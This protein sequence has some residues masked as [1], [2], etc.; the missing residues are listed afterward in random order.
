MLAQTLGMRFIEMTPGRFLMGSPPD[1]IGREADEQQHEVMLTRSFWIADAP[2]TVAQYRVKDP[3]HK[4]P[5]LFGIALDD[6]RYPC[7]WISIEEAKAYCDWLSAQDTEWTYELPTEAE[8]EYA[9]RAGTAGRFFWGDTEADASRFANTFDRSAMKAL[10]NL[11]KDGFDVDDGFVGPSP[12][13]SFQ[14]NRYGLYDVI[15]NAW[16]YCRNVAYKYPATSV[17]DPL[18]PPTGTLY[19]VRGGD[20]LSIPFFARLA[21]RTFMR[22]GE[23]SETVGFRVIARPRAQLPADP[24][25]P[26]PPSW[27]DIRGLFTDIDVAHMKAASANWKPP[28]ELDS[29]ESVKHYSMKVYSSVR[30][31]RMPLPPVDKWNTF[32]KDLL[33]RWIYARHPY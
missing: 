7:T 32:Q 33:R 13:R 19:C 2:V 16:Q 22:A 20:W 31:D 25:D 27:V 11:P 14:P 1:E 24:I 23:R 21:N 28:L 9:A 17:T 12:I 3:S 4:C 5:P 8:W 10:G 30:D 26:A 29:Y 18:G 6:D 15:G